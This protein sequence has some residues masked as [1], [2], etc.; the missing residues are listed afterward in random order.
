MHQNELDSILGA[1]MEESMEILT[2]NPT[3]SIGKEVEGKEEVFSK[4]SFWKSYKNNKVEEKRIVKQ[5]VVPE[6]ILLPK[7]ILPVENGSG[8]EKVKGWRAVGQLEN[9]IY[10]KENIGTVQAKGD[11]DFE[12]VYEKTGSKAD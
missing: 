7:E 5:V 11:M 2:V 12:A 4:I 3:Y 1:A 6:G 10:T 8:D 9:T